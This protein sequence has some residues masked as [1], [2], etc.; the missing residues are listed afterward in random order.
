MKKKP[1]SLVVFLLLSLPVSSTGGAYLGAKL[2][3][4]W[5]SLKS[6]AS[7]TLLYRY[8]QYPDLPAHL[9]RPLKIC[10][11]LAVFVA[12]LP[13]LALLFALLAKP[14]R[15]LHGSSRFATFDEVKKAGL[16][17]RPEPSG[18]DKTRSRKETM[19]ALLIGKFQGEYRYYKG[20]AFLY[21]A[22]PTRSG[23]GVGIVIPNCLNYRDSLVVY[24]PKLENFL[25]TSG[26]R[27]RHGHKVFL[28]N[29]SGKM[30]EHELNPHA[31]LVSHK[32]NPMTYIRRNPLFTFKDLSN[33][34]TILF[35]T[36]RNADGSTMFFVESA[37]KLFV[38]LGL[39]LIETEQERRREAEREKKLDGY[40]WRTT[41]TNL[42]KLTT[43]QD[44]GSLAQWVKQTLKLRAMKPKTDLSSQCRT[45]LQEFAN[46]DQETAMNILAS[47]TAPLGIFLD[48]VVEM[49][50]SDD[51]FRLDQV[52]QELMTVYVGVVPTEAATFS[53]L[54]NL[55]FSQLIDVNVQQGLPE[56]NPKL[57]Y[58]CL[59]LLD[60]FTALGAIP[61]V[62][63]G[64]SYIAGYGLR[65]LI[66]IQA[67][68]Q[69]E[70]VY[71]RDNMKTF[72]TNFNCRIFY[73]PREQ[74][75]CEEYSKIIGYE[76]FKARSTS[77]SSGRGSSNSTSVSDQ[78]RAVMN[79]D[80]LRLM[81]FE[82]CIIN[83][84]GSR[85]IFAEKIIYHEDPEF[86]K[87]AWLRPP[88]IPPLFQHSRQNETQQSAG[89]GRKAVQV[90]DK[91]L[92]TVQPPD[93]LNKRAK[94]LEAVLQIMPA[95][96]E[97]A[98]LA[99]CVTRIAGL[100]QLDT[101]VLAADVA[102]QRMMQAA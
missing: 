33:M 8:W 60:E 74:D 49:A 54:L 95:D 37:R 98:M 67:P 29:P 66:I 36:P 53:R 87:R 94:A 28:F 38:G 64:V 93:V 97:D 10:T 23:K 89:D 44:G 75:D 102:A 70:A 99:D 4:V 62:Q 40:G 45:L 61:A 17:F 84:G 56:N 3:V 83:L 22:A 51:D 79:P 32:W 27:A 88:T 91:L 9:I 43:P 13:A 80:E 81:P 39:Y 19:P 7:V 69:V 92:Y 42:F 5:K 11:A 52:R 85:A 77:R 46:N 63:H 18:K 59:L 82:K 41:L 86:K 1:L 21:L 90:P 25:I 12:L 58:Q 57:Q 15:E 50:T 101:T 14:R 65:L 48:P 6:T 78:R 26:F 76:T 100:Y 96:A 30:P 72:F 47:M 20:D 24:D 68:S 31:P 71:G 2:F 73:T 35:P 16:L 55:F 34:A